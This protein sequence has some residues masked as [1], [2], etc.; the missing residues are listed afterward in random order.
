MKMWGRSPPG[1]ESTSHDVPV[2]P[3]HSR[4]HITAGLA[5]Q[6][7]AHDFCRNCSKKSLEDLHRGTP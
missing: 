5:G 1:K 4:G 3:E 7:E 6:G 2:W